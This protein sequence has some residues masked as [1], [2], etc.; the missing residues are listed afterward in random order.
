M[1]PLSLTALNGY[2]ILG[3]GAHV[4]NHLQVEEEEEEVCC[5]EVGGRGEGG[6]G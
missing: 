6:G 3:K 2:V 1:V 5:E 4:F